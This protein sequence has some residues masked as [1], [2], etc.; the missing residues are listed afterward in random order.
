MSQQFWICLAHFVHTFTPRNW[1]V[2]QK[3]PHLRISWINTISWISIS[4]SVN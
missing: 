1:T 4:S 3:N 2:P